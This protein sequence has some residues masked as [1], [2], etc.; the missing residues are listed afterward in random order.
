MTL[1]NKTVYLDPCPVCGKPWRTG[2]S[3][4]TWSRDIH[5]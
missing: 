5:H 3:D 2:W 1:T 4:N